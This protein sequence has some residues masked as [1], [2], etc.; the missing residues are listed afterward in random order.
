MISEQRMIQTGKCAAT[1]QKQPPK[2]TSSMKKQVFAGIASPKI[3]INFNVD[4]REE[5]T[6]Q[7]IQQV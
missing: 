6:R 3:Q 2:P 7:L 4:L 5:H 1:E